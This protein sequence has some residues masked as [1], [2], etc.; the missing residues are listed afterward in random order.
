MPMGLVCCVLSCLGW[1]RHNEVQTGNAGSL[2]DAEEACCRV[3]LF[4]DV[5]LWALS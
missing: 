5:L 2:G 1:A 3:L 4:R